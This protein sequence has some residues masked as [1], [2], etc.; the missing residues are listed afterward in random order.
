MLNKYGYHLIYKHKEESMKALLTDA[1]T[2]EIQQSLK[3]A[4]SSQMIFGESRTVN[5]KEV[6]PVSSIQIQLGASSSAKGGGEGEQKSGFMNAPKLMG[7]GSGESAAGASI[8]IELTPVG[9]LIDENG[10]V[11]FKS[12]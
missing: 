7:G 6:I 8:Q 2:K 10:E 5:G 12:F 9:F 4:E 11:Q 1:I 3:L